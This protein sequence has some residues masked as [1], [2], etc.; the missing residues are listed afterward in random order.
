MSSDILTSHLAQESVE[1]LIT[2]NV[3]RFEDV[4][5]SIEITS[6]ESF[7]P[8]RL[9]ANV[10]EPKGRYLCSQGGQ[11]SAPLGLMG[12]Y[13]QDLEND[14]RKYIEMML[15]C[16]SYAEDVTAGDIFPLRTKILKLI[17]KYNQQE[18]VS[19]SVLRRGSFW[20]DSY[21]II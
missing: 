19:N 13:S 1:K 12:I 14:C 5:F 15:C 21:R 3:Q 18:D 16:K 11:Y 10:F 8:L 7:A 20:T 9:E 6:G 2:A 4:S 17:F